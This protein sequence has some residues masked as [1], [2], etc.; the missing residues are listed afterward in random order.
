[1]PHFALICRDKPGHLETRMANRESHL[2]YLT[3]YEGL[4]TAGPLLEDGA[5]VGSLVVI[6]AAARA[7]AEGF[8]AA[9]PYAQAGLFASVEISEWKKVFG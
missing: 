9:D 5:P 8:A 6:E 2:A 4:F 3:G 7:A 1:M